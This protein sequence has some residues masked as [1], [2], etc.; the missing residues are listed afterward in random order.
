MLRT[1][2]L[3]LTQPWE[4]Q[5]RWKRPSQE[6]E[7]RKP[8][9]D[10]EWAPEMKQKHRKSLPNGR[11]QNPRWRRAKRAAPLGQRRRRRLVVF[12]LVRI[13]CVF[14]SFPEPILGRFLLFL[15]LFSGKGFSSIPGAPTKRFFTKSLPTRFGDSAPNLPTPP[16]TM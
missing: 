8:K 2:P 9:I 12:H 5:G 3:N 7:C 13:S 14:A 10:P 16:T 15:V 6:K 1:L 11:Q 4:G